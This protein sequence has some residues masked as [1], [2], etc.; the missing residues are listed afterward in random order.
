MSDIILD[1]CMQFE[2]FPIK[3]VGEEAF[4]SYYIIYHYFKISKIRQKF[5]NS[6]I[7][8]KSTSQVSSI[9]LDACMQYE[10]YPIKTV[11]EEAFYSY[12]IIYHY[13]KISKIR[14]KFKN[15]PIVK[16]S[17]SQ[18]SGIILDACMQYENYPIKTVGEE[19]FYSYYILYHYFK[20]SKICQKFK[21]SPIV[22]K[23]QA[24]WVI[25]FLMPVCN[26]KTIR[27]KLWV[28]RRFTVTIYYT[29]ISKFQKFAKNSKIVRSSKKST[30]QVSGIILDACM[31]YENYPIKTVGEEAFYSYYIL[32]HYFKISKICQ[33]FKNSPIIKKSTSQVGD[34]ILDACV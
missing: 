20:I 33:K 1:A 14:Q 17:T 29:I 8:I 23:A 18:V 24:R 28:K 31:Q 34:I 26:M 21:N 16:K 25:S 22:K 4:Y 2:N 5:K 9:I 10:N 11:G 7:V 13:F 15:S 12:Y 6:L 27:L 30:S 3:T 32:Y 19:A